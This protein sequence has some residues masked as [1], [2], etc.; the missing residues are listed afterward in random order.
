M[1]KEI[2]IFS[3]SFLDLLSG[4]L[5]AV[6]ILY[7]IIPK[8]SA[9]DEEVLK[10]INKMQVNVNQIDSMMAQLENSVDK[11]LFA[12]LEDKIRKMNAQMATLTVEVRH[13]QGKVKELQAQ[14]SKCREKLARLESME[15]EAKILKEQI[16]KLNQEIIEKREE[17]QAKNEEISNL[18]NENRELSK[19]R[20]W[21][22]QCRFTLDDECPPPVNADIGFKF[23]GKR[24]VFILDASGSMLEASNGKEDR[25]YPVKAAVKMILAVMGGDF[26]A[27]VVQFPYFTASSC[28]AYRSNW[29]TVK[30]LNESNKKEAYQ[31]I[32]T[33]MSKQGNGTPSEEAILY[34]LNNYPDISDIVFISDGTPT[35]SCDDTNPVPIDPI[36]QKIRNTNRGRVRINSIG[37]GSDFFA[38]PGSDQVRFMTQLAQDNNNGFFIGL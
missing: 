29:Q 10:T 36:L 1:G 37:V 9:Q 17:L 2:H 27:D 38:N 8:I 28:T 7:I 24:I 32:Y 19:Y 21:M 33:I 11:E 26:S 31:F 14:L 15:K 22:E 13:L 16:H 3:V 25:L 35:V 18:K 30:P 5:G 6:I 20:E 23:K 34:V 4:A 12:Q